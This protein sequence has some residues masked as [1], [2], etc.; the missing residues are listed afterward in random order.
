[1]FDSD[2][3]AAAAERA[4]GDAGIPT[5]AV[6]RY[7]TNEAGSAQPSASGQT[8][9]GFWSWLLGEETPR[10]PDYDKD[11][12]YYERRARAGSTILSVT[13]NDDSQIHRAVEIIESH[14]PVEIDERTDEDDADTAAPVSTT[15]AGRDFSS[16]ATTSAREGTMSGAMAGGMTTDTGSSASTAS[17]STGQHRSTATGRDETIPLAEE[18]IE[19]GKRTVDRGTTRIRRYVVEKPVEREVSLH[20]ERVTIE[21]RQPVDRTGAPGAGAFEERVVE[22]REQEEVPVVQKSAHVAEEVVVHR[23]DTDR[24]ETVRD[25]VRREEI[26]VEGDKTRGAGSTGSDPARGGKGDR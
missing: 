8:G 17:T 21:R 23:E 14:D 16:S 15:T 6:R 7:T 4:L 2:G 11:M 26:E 5:S 25:T 3:P 20:G 9:G 24:T 22:V 13:I 19:I 12:Q 10:Y 1:M 18:D